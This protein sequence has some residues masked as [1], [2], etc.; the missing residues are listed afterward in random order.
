MAPTQT[1]LAHTDAM[2]G[3]IGFHHPNRYR[4]DATAIAGSRSFLN[5]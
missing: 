4:L 3:I 1:F 5:I 2:D